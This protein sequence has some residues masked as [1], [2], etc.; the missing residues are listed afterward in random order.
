MPLFC[1]QT[2]SKYTPPF[3]DLPTVAVGQKAIMS[4]SDKS[5]GQ[6]V[7]QKYSDKLH[8]SDGDGFGAVLGL[9]INIRPPTRKT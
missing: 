3:Q 5:S 2:S 7:K 1:L 8:G 4:D 9:Q 6:T